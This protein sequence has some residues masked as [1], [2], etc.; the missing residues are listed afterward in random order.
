MEV[1]HHKIRRVPARKQNMQCKK[2]CMNESVL[3]I[4]VKH[5]DFFFLF[6]YPASAHHRS[7]SF[8]Q[9]RDLVN[10]DDDNDE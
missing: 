9:A 10:C 3:C 4:P 6:N 5:I 2:P 8:E 7:R 1:K